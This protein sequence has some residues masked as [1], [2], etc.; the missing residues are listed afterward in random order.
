MF[1]KAIQSYLKEKGHN[2]INLKAVLFD[3]DGILLKYP[4]AQKE[5]KQDNQLP[6]TF[7]KTEIKTQKPLTDASDNF[8][9][10]LLKSDRTSPNENK[11]LN[12]NSISM[13]NMP[14]TQV[15][16]RKYQPTNTD[17]YNQT[18]K[19]AL[20]EISN[21]TNS[22]LSLQKQQT[23][24]PMINQGYINTYSETKKVTSIV[25]EKAKDLKDKQKYFYFI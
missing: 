15:K 21:F 19:D 25:V 8:E 13:K 6:Y 22:R 20:N 2:K 7:N 24:E 12:P 11:E 10:S 18:N 14:I 5:N 9:R 16:T 4:S 1:E 17:L 3:M 23:L